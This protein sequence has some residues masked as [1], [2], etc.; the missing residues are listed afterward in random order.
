MWMKKQKDI[1]YI[2]IIGNKSNIKLKYKN[3]I[4]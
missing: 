2:C 4:K 3:K 1:Y